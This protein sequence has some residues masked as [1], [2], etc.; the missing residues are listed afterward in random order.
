M[1]S[2]YTA[3]FT[4][5]QSPMEAYDAI[6]DVRAWWTGEIEGDSRAL[7]DEFTYRHEDVHLSTQRVVDLLPGQRV[8]WTVVEGYLAFVEDKQEWAGT[9]ITFDI[10]RAGDLTEVRF[11]HVGLTPDIECFG[12]C[13]DAWGYYVNTSLRELIQARPAA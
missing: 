3:T 6:N 8:V 11:S 13:S 4:V 1:S 12:A 10:S 9:T 7:G 2:D 5:Q